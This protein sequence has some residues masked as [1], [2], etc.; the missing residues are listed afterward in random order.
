MK[1]PNKDQSVFRKRGK[2][3]SITGLVIIISLIALNITIITT[4]D[5]LELML[6]GTPTPTRSSNSFLLEA[7][8][9]VGAG[10][11]GGAIS[12]YE[13][14]LEFNPGN[15]EALVELARLQVYYSRLLTP[16]LGYEQLLRA[17]DNI[18]KAVELDPESS[19][20]QAILALVL[21]W[22]ATNAS[23]PFEER[24][25]YLLE[26]NQA[27]T[28]ALQLNNR[29]ALALA[30]RAEIQAD[31]LRFDQATQLAQ[32]AVALEPNSMDTHRVYAYILESTRYYSQA[33]EEYKAAAAIEPNM[34][35]LYIS[36]GQNYR[37]LQLYDQALEYFDRA[38]SIN[39]SI[40][41]QDPLPYLAIAKTYTRQGQ[42]FAAA[43]NAEVALSFDYTNPDLYGQLGYIR[44]QARNFEGSIPMLECAV[45]GCEV[46]YDEFFGVIPQTDATEEQLLTL[47]RIQVQGLPLSNASV[48]YYYVY[49]SMLAAFGI[50]DKA[51]IFLDLL[52]NEYGGDPTIMSIVQENRQVCRIFE[53]EANNN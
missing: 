19:N 33:I 32:Q 47:D 10:N 9:L 50:C 26:A 24:E 28:V 5:D 52:E 46:L 3:F 42:F 11:L 17:Y 20:A 18:Q 30:F 38:A 7:Q 29:N 43:R 14:A 4:A 22:L 21:D 15:V 36:I 25:S 51:T 39:K 13:E 37:Q 1:V 49:S 8:A 45:E 41:I 23:T 34:T 40:G 44:S 48:V 31:L 6:V 27:A 53:E 16:N 35:F 12:A 2:M